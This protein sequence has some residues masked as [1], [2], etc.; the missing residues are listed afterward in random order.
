LDYGC[1]PGNDVV[2]F[3]LHT[4]AKQVIGMDVFAEGVGAGDAAE[5]RFTRSPGTVFG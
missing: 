3:L 4:N 5:L 1:G 2:G